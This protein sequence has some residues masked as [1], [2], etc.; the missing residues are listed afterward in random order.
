MIFYKSCMTW[1]TTLDIR[2]VH[3]HMMYMLVYHRPFYERLHNAEVKSSDLGIN[4]IK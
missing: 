1:I 3:V 2:G 4:Q